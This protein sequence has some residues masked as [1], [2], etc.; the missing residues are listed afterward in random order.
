MGA[1]V[2]TLQDLGGTQSM[3]MKGAVSKPLYQVV[4]CHTIEFVASDLAYAVR[5]SIQLRQEV[6]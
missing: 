1:N 3:R 4:Q 2:L 6:P 5:L